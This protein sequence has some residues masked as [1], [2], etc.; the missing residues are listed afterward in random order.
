MREIIRCVDFVKT[1]IV[2]YLTNYISYWFYENVQIDSRLNFK[3]IETWF[4]RYSF[5]N[6]NWN[7]FLLT[8]LFSIYPSGYI[9]TCQNLQFLASMFVCRFVCLLVCQFC[10]A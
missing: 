6:H 4:N 3:T 5:M 10:Q 9:I 7:V 2:W 8:I 1:E